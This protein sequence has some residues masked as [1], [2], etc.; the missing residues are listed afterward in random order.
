[1]CQ[2]HTDEVNVCCLA[3]I[4]CVVVCV[5]FSE[6]CACVVCVGYVVNSVCCVSSVHVCSV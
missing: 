6:L 4:L 5:G 2:R 3:T 1:M